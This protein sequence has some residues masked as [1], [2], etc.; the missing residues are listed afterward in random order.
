MKSKKHSY[1]CSSV[2]KFSFA[3]T[4]ADKHALA[5]EHADAG[6]LASAADKHARALP[7]RDELSYPFSASASAAVKR[8]F[9]P[10]LAVQGAFLFFCR[11][12]CVSSL[13]LSFFSFS[14]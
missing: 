5:D 4:G 14:F 1:P 12:F 13:S 9:A 6:A 11:L 3:D 10:V 2:D 7:D 8:L